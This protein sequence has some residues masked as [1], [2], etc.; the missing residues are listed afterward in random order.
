MQ[1]KL[2]K[3]VFC[4]HFCNLFNLILNKEYFPKMWSVGLIVPM[5]KSDGCDDPS[6]YRGIAIT[7]CVGKLFTS[8]LNQRKIE[9]VEK[10]RIVSHH[11]IGIKNPIEL[12]IISSL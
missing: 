5:Y 6:N 8:V 10:Q 12:L 11:Q 3:L 2:L 1:M 7:S 4:Q 9:F